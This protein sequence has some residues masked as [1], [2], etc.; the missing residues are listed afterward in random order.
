MALSAFLQKLLFVNQFSISGGKI[1]MLGNRYIMLNASD[2]LVLQKIDETIAYNLGK[3]MAKKQFSSM[4]EH[5]KVYQGIKNESLKNIA[6]LS[7]K[8]EKSEEGKMKV[9]EEIFDI[10]GLGRLQIVDLDNKNCKV[11]LKIDN[12]TISQEYLKDK[13]NVKSKSG[14]C[15]LTAGILAGIFTFL[16]KKKVECLEESCQA[17]GDGSCIFKIE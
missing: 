12:S 3:N 2:I 16:F 6:E 9:L 13:N 5:A 7:K 4:V 11:S 14:V 17:K 10:Y 8:I 1:E 15:V